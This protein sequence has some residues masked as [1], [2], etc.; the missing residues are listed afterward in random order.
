MNNPVKKYF[1]NILF[2]NIFPIV[3]I[4]LILFIYFM[5]AE[6][7]P[8]TSIILFQINTIYL[9]LINIMHSII[10]RNKMFILNIIFMILSCLIGILLH[11]FFFKIILVSSFSPDIGDTV[12]VF[13]TMLINIPIVSIIG[14]IEQVILIFIYLKKWKNKEKQTSA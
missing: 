1:T 5:F 8:I 14:I 11:Y 10:C 12:F 6:Y 3:F 7:N 4:N 9:L 2:L 13:G